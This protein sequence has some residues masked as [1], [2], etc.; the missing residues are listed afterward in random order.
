MADS[1]LT[2]TAHANE[3]PPY[4]RDNWTDTE[5]LDWLD[6]TLQGQFFSLRNEEEN[7]ALYNNSRANRQLPRPLSFRETLAL[8]CSAASLSSRYQ[9]DDEK[10]AEE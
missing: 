5:L 1:K 7:P 8:F 3:N 9:A 6:S 2:D 4:R 10:E